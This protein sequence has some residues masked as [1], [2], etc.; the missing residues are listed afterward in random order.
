MASC[1]VAAVVELREDR[2]EG[3]RLHGHRRQ[4]D[5]GEGRRRAS[6]PR[7]SPTASPTAGA[8]RLSA[9]PRPGRAASSPRSRPASDRPRIA[10]ALGTDGDDDRHHHRRRTSSALGARDARVARR[11]PR[12]RSGRSSRS[13][14]RWRSSRSSPT[15]SCRRQNLSLVL[16]QVMVVGV[17]A[18]GQT[19][20]ILT[21]GI[22]LSVGTVM[23]FGQIVMTKLAVEN[24]VPA[25]PAI[26]L[27]ILACVGLR[28]P[29]RRPGDA[30]SGCRPSS[31]RSARSTSRSR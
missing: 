15:A 2:Q 11:S 21:A 8:R 24:G 5:R 31:S 4:P 18:I 20:V 29:E 30:A 6:P 14:W 7:A 28:R 19:L 1:G 3:V 16:Q 23:A 22:D 26:L 12:R 17:L 10:S 9:E 25:L 27:G 13:C